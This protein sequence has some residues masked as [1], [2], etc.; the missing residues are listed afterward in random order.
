MSGHTV[1]VLNVHAPKLS[2]YFPHMCN[3]ERHYRF[4]AFYQ[5]LVSHRCPFHAASLK[6]SSSLTVSMLQ[7]VLEASISELFP[8]SWA[9]VRRS[10]A[11][12]G[13]DC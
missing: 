8:S 9:A 10:G 5:H 3:H 2:A 6:L 1:S 4:R 7:I 13:D 11:V 12:R